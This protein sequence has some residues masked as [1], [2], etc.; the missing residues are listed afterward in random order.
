MAQVLVP[1]GVTRCRLQRGSLLSGV[2]TSFRVPSLLCVASPFL[3]SLAVNIGASEWFPVGGDACTVGMALLAVLHG[4]I[5]LAT[6][7]RQEWPHRPV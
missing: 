4:C 3:S 1:Y 6:A 5:A 2:I 7:R